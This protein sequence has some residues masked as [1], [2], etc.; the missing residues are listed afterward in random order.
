MLKRYLIFA[1]GGNHK[2]FGHLSRM[3]NL[4]FKLGIEDSVICLFEN[5]GQ[6]FF[7]KEHK[8]NKI[9]ALVDIYDILKFDD[10]I[11]IID[12][13]DDHS[14]MLENLEKYLSKVIVI[15][16][17]TDLIKKADVKVSPA[18]YAAN[19]CN[20]PM[21]G[22]I[23]KFSGINYV[24]IDDNFLLPHHKE[25]KSHLTLSFG[26][27]DPNNITLRMLKLIK[28][29]DRFLEDLIVILGPGYKHDFQEIYKYVH[30]DQVVINPKD[31]F[32]IFQKSYIV[33]TAMGVTVQELFCMGIPCGI[34]YNYDYDE[35]DLEKITQSSNFY[36]PEE[37][38]IH[39]FGHFESVD[40]EQLLKELNLRK[41]SNEIFN[42]LMQAGHLW[43]SFLD[44]VS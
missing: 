29:Q 18:F 31:I 36:R 12:S 22:T 16:N 24:I 42:P 9:C 43:K 27:Y 14:E 21:R 20:D 35:F 4:I 32:K 28:S 41:F 15:D 44:D 37:D 34:V 19:E 25:N 11:L 6:Q 13:K 17:N 38:I 8:F 3:K 2:G 1:D 33:L 30:P 5:N 26:G 7:W 40:Q 23:K 10:Y 39:S